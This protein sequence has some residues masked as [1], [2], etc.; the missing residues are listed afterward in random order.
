MIGHQRRLS[1]KARLGIAT[2]ALAVLIS[3]AGGG[4]VATQS[5]EG[6]G[7]V[8][9]LVGR[10]IVRTISH[11]VEE[12]TDRKA[13][14]QR[15][16]AEKVQ[17][18]QQQQVLDFQRGRGWLDQTTYE[19]ESARLVALKKGMDERA[20]RERQIVSFQT[21]NNIRSDLRGTVRDVLTVSTGMNPK[22][23]D[24]A[25]SLL[26]GE[27][28]ITAAINAAL[29]GGAVVDPRQQFRDLRQ[30][31]S[32]VENGLRFVRDHR[33]ILA[34]AELAA[35]LRDMGGPDVTP[36]EAEEAL[37]RA[38]KLG[39]DVEKAVAQA[40]AIKKDLLPRSPG[41]DRQR[42]ANNGEWIRRNDNVQALSA[43]KAG[44]AVLAGLLRA[45]DER[46]EERVKALLGERGIT[47][48]DEELLKIAKEA[49]SA[50]KAARLQDGK[51]VDASKVN[52]DEIVRRAVDEAL[53]K[54]GLNPLGTPLPKATQTPTAGP[55]E[56]PTAEPEETPTAE[57]EE[58]PTAEPTETPTAGPTETPTVEATETPTAEPEETPSPE[59]TPSPSP[60]PTEAPTPTP[61][62][63]AVPTPEAQEITAVGQYLSP[64]PG[65]TIDQNTMTLVF[66]TA[67]GPGSVT[68][69]NGSFATSCVVWEECPPSVDSEEIT[70]EGAYDPDSKTFEG[71]WT[72]QF[73]S[74]Y[75][76]PDG[77]GHCEADEQSDTMSGTWQATLSGGAIQGDHGPDGM[78]FTLA[79]QG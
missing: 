16:D 8:E 42:F 67:G 79:V 60:E 40:G 2:L 78:P 6:F 76:M 32:E 10:A 70:Y 3:A 77:E 69:G 27:R 36:E 65:C 54:R 52:I 31:L 68:Q 33:G 74:T 59:A 12:K 39:E 35:I 23:I 4:L 15:R 43:S 47:L 38:R 56:T 5:V 44:E 30:T 64:A 66:N 46:A 28:P 37:N 50:Y 13:I 11:K 26:R 22:A 7:I 55:T 9:A 14:N 58:T 20:T 48:T 1:L 29:A 34:R 18:N 24:F 45:A 19:R 41:I 25:S 75:Y 57:P 71:T 53:A 17:V 61:Q 51:V 21:R 73:D 63:T 62:P 72:L 49:G